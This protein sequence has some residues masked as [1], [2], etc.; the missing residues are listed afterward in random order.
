MFC[1]LVDQLNAFRERSE[2]GFQLKAD[3][4]KRGGMRDANIVTRMS[5]PASNC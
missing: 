5:H 3:A 4:D 2:R 1:G